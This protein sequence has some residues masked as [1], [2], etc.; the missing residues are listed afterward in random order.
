MGNIPHALPVLPT[1]FVGRA[2]EL[3]SISRML[4]AGAGQHVTIVG[5]GG[6]GKTRL[7]VAVAR[8]LLLDGEFEDGIFFV[9]LAGLEDGERIASV[10]AEA[11]QFRLELGE[12]QLLAFV[13]A[14]RILLILDNFEHL[15]DYSELISSLIE[16]APQLRILVTSRERLKLQGEQVFP[17]GGLN[18]DKAASM[19]DARRLFLQAARRIQPD[20]RLEENLPALNRICK[21]VE[22]M[23]LALEL[24][25]AWVNL[26]SIDDIAAEIMR[27][28]EFLATDL[29]DV[30]LRHRSMRAVFDATWKQL[31]PEDQQLLARLSVFRGGFSREASEAV[32]LATLRQLGTLVGKSLLN[33]D[34]A[35]DRYHIHELLRQYSVG[36]LADSDVLDS[37]TDYMFDWLIRQSDNLAGDRQEESIVRI[38]REMDN[39]RAAINHALRAQRLDRL[40][41]VLR[42]MGI[43]ARYR[44]RQSEVV[45][46]FKNV[47]QELSR[48]PDV[49]LHTLFWATALFA[50][51][52][53]A[54][55]AERS[56]S[57][58][59]R[60]DAQNL[61]T[62]MTDSG[63]DTRAEQAYVNY[64]EAYDLYPVDPPRARRLLQQ[65]YELSMALNE[66]IAA[67]EALRVQVRA[68]RNEGNI[69]A[70][71]AIVDNA[72][73][74]LR[75]MSNHRYLSEFQFLAGNLAA[76]DG[77]Y[78]EAEQKLLA[79]IEAGQLFKGTWWLANSGLAKLQMVYLFSG[80]FD[81]AVAPLAEY[82]QLSEEFDSSW[83]LV[84]GTISKGV[85]SLHRGQYAEAL[86]LADAVIARAAAVGSLDFFI[87]EAL[88][89]IAQAEIVL[90]NEESAAIRLRECDRLCQIRP[91][92][93]PTYIAGNAL[94]WSLVAAAAGEL[95]SAWEYLHAEMTAA[96]ERRD[97]LNL[98][99]AVAIIAYLFVLQKNAAA[100]LRHYTIATQHP[101]VA[102][103][104]WFADLVGNRVNALA[105]DLSQV[106]IA[107]IRQGCQDPDL[108]TVVAAIL[109]SSSL[110]DKAA[111]ASAGTQ[112]LIEP[113]SARELELLRLVVAGRSNREIAAELFL[114]LGTV[115][116]HLHNIYQK[117]GVR[118][119]TQAIALASELNLL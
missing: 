19:D 97:Q 2:R 116:S 46:V 117:M 108:E 72:M 115:K 112:P 32:A 50:S 62:Q 15:L 43:F 82:C 10:I 106:E 39:I 111:F 98:A 107:S 99:N 65:S 80:R 71:E 103:S 51:G 76:I 34:S 104:K 119:R 114:A 64:L 55:V 20:L 85:L 22:G 78:E 31:G 93:M 45:Q 30:P 88:S 33:F 23:P 113:L 52:L 61:L 47:H 86:I 11:M 95:D 101:F 24:A 17:I 118:S 18:V 37:H 74:L 26:L 60:Q 53:N 7:A 5:P 79:G 28:L 44:S 8:R 70:A 100:A 14:K 58:V 92:G 90:G 13:R 87:C 67:V 75:E 63:W 12:S 54:T 69:P 94:Y 57:R 68:V 84:Q 59:M 1:P 38:E 42:T 4:T 3:S 110:A 109:A 16:A 35:T 89:L 36:R 21:L 40:V 48:M 77:R 91:V 73:G 96:Y 56:N 29:R 27:S 49:S 9:P 81:E 83:G 41:P 6:M 66:P 25:A 105:Q 102:N